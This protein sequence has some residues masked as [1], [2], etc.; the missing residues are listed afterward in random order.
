[1][2]SLPS[3]RSELKNSIDVAELGVGII[4]MKKVTKRAVGCENKN[5]AEI[6]RDKVTNDMDEK[7]IT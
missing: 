5:Q 2:P 6:L 3:R 1:M 4:T 7:Y